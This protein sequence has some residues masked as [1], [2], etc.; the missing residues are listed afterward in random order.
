MLI[1]KMI[2]IFRRIQWKLTLS[3]SAVTV[4]SLFVVVFILGYLLFTK[5]FIPIE[6]YNRDLTP[7]DWI[8]I[9]A[10]N[11]AAL[12]RSILSQEPID[13]G[14]IA[15]MMQEGELTITDIEILQVG[16][17]QIRV[18]TEGSGSTI[19]VDENGIL[20][21]I[22][23]PHF[24]YKERYSAV[25]EPI[26]TALFPGLESVLTAALNG[27]TDPEK[28]FVSLEPQEQFFFAVP[29]MEKDN[30]EVLGAVIIYLEHLP[31]ANDIPETLLQLLGQSVVIF[32]IAAAIVGTI[33]GALTARAMA[34]RLDN[35]SQTTDAWSQ[36]DFSRFIEDSVGDEI[37]QLT[38][39]LNNMA[40]QLQQFLKRSQEIAVS[41]ERNRLA[42]DLHDSA[43]QEA[44]AASFHLGTALTL[45]ERD[46]ESAKNHLVEAETLVDSVRGELTDLIH[47]LRPIS[48]N[49]TR[50]DETLNEY[51]IEWAHQTGIEVK[52]K[53]VG[54]VDLSLEIKQAI[55]RIMQEALANV[56]RH[57]S[58]D[59][60]EVTMRFDNNMVEFCIIDD[61]VGFDIQQQ[62]DGIGLASMHE[63]VESL[64]GDFNIE[65]KPGQG[66][67]VCLTIPIKE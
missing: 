55:Y 25:G 62:H 16:S 15:A 61:G 14:L 41:E 60:V 58:A 24:V 20:V 63:R 67:K 17:V 1:K 34:L 21:G 19:L 30:H 54:F 53:I 47:E 42:R 26:N 3:Y 48:M 6:V 51:L 9:V 56:A 38:D 28:L 13:M 49:G 37:S 12:A 50:F 46:P 4:G 11:D 36:G 35:I 59:I 31:T 18:R 27:E 32:L 33:F 57:S 66:T 64:T 45:F 29:V 44:L 40:A 39:R 10:E 22:S 23:N 5:A 7:D 2:R 43:K 65:S 52:L 8:R